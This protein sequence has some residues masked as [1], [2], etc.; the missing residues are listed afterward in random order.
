MGESH[1]LVLKIELPYS[2]HTIRFA[3]EGITISHALQC[4]PMEIPDL[5]H[6][7]VKLYF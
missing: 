1:G 2:S 3:Q 4:R 7:Q 6:C 5:V